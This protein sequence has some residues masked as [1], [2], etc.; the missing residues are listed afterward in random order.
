MSTGYLYVAIGEK[1]LRECRIS[2]TSLRKHDSTAHVTLVTDKISPTCDLFD[3]VIVQTEET[4]RPYLYKIRGVQATPY[5]Y[6]LFVDTDTYFCANCQEL[7]NLLQ[8][9]DV[10]V[11]PCPNDNSAVFDEQNQIVEGYYPYNTGI[12][13]YKKKGGTD[14][15]L[16]KWA[17]AYIRHFDKYIHDQP[18]FVEALLYCDVKLYV[19]STIYNARTPY[20]SMFIGKRVKIIHG[21]HRN[22]PRIERILN[23]KHLHNRV[24]YP[25]LQWVLHQQT[26]IFFRWYMRLKPEYRKKIKAFLRL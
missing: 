4:H 9:Y 26:T 20:P 7:F 2:L 21:R 11:A 22:Y 13:A 3:N 16:E 5:E 24:W 8:Y 1:H 14:L 23:R 17:D 15:F 6:T 25:R 10:A 18:P 19:M 12:I